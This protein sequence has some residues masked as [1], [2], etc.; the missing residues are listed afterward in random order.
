MVEAMTGRNI[1]CPLLSLQRGVDQINYFGGQ[2]VSYGSILSDAFMF[3][4]KRQ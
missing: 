1:F 3:G 4:W 2:A